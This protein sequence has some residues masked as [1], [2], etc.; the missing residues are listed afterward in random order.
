MKREINDK[1]ERETEVKLD[2]KIYKIGGMERN[3]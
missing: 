3:G 2:L 1:P